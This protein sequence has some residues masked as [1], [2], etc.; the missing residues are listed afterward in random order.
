MVSKADK[1]RRI[2]LTKKK[3]RENKDI[4]GPYEWGHPS[5][6]QPGQTEVCEV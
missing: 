3:H 2:L 5:V 1:R 6:V 4:L